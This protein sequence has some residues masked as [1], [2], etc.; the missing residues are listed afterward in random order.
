MV[1][2]H[3][4]L[5]GRWVQL[6]IAKPKWHDVWQLGRVALELYEK[7][8]KFADLS[9]FPAL[10]TLSPANSLIIKAAFAVLHLVPSALSRQVSQLMILVLY[11]QAFRTAHEATK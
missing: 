10:P 9:K 7:V 1:P 4:Q 6:V 5:A 2:M 8:L 11:T 3:I